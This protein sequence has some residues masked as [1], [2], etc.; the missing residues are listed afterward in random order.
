[1]NKIGSYEIELVNIS[2]KQWDDFLKEHSNLPGSGA[3]LELA[4]AF[5]RI[6]TLMDFKKYIQLDAE[7][8]PANTPDEFLAFCGVLGYG[9]YLSKYHDSGLMLQLKERANDPRQRIR[10]GVVRALQTIGGE[11]VSRFTAYVKSWIEGTFL[12]Q[13]AAVA[14]VCGMDLL[15]NEETALLALELLD[16]ATA[17]MVEKDD[18]QNE[19]YKELQKALSDY[20]SRA[21]TALP[22]KGK[23]MVERWIKEDHP[24]VNK[25]MRENLK[26]QWLIDI[27]PEWAENWLQKISN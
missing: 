26:K 24:V 4:N 14:A 19:G 1:M 21:V 22:A 15:I 5:A 17:T 8:A 13:R 2:P 6:G 18:Q 7:E 25:I 16:W 12:E 10:E 20:W 3:N 11:K 23:P 9:H 27:E